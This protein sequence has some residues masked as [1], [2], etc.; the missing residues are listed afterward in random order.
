MIGADSS[1]LESTRG[2]R[3]RADLLSGKI[4]EERGQ[5]SGMELGPG[6]GRDLDAW[7]AWA[8]DPLRTNSERFVFLERVWY[9]GND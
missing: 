5:K 3:L 4:D 7:L 9:S 6:L 2:H 8:G 1:R